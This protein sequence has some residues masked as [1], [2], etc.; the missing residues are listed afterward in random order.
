MVEPFPLREDLRVEQ[1]S[2]ERKDRLQA[3][4]LRDVRSFGVCMLD[5][6]TVSLHTLLAEAEVRQLQAELEKAR[7]SG[8]GC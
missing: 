6:W 5:C 8:S 1:L 4:V 2:L 7:G 3:E